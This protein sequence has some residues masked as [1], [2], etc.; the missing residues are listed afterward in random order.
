MNDVISVA[1]VYNLDFL[2]F[3]QVFLNSEDICHNLTGV[4][5]VSEAVDDWAFRGIDFFCKEYFKSINIS[6]KLSCH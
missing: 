2:L 5:V 1:E 6:L 4:V 3:W